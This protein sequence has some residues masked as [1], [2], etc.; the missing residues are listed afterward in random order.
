ME[1]YVSLS[2]LRVDNLN[3]FISDIYGGCNKIFYKN[4]NENLT[5]YTVEE[6]ETKKKQLKN[7]MAKYPKKSFS[8]A[9]QNVVEVAFSLQD[10][11]LSRPRIERVH[12]YIFVACIGSS[13]DLIYSK[14]Q[15][16]EIVDEVTILFGDID[17]FIKVY[18][19][20]REI[21][22]LITEDI[23]SIKGATIN[24]TKTYF[25]FNEQVWMKHPVAKHPNYKPPSSRWYT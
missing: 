17:I 3:Q 1:K 24:S 20:L 22:K 13:A 15:E 21:K 14:I 5:R 11:V 25:S 10:G 18:A 4:F 2:D 12:A 7:A 19:T 16:N 6:R 8:Q 9:L 23:F